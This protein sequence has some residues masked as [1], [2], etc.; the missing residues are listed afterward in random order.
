MKRPKAWMFELVDPAAL[1][2]VDRY[3][4]EVMEPLSAP[5]NGRDEVGILEQVEVLRAGEL[6]LKCFARVRRGR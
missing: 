6:G 3:G 2:L 5:P 1:Q 4:I